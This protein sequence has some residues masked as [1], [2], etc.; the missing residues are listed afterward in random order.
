MVKLLHHIQ[1]QRIYKK[2]LTSWLQT[3]P[4]DV[5]V[6]L[7][8]KEIEWLGKTQLSCKKIAEL[9]FAIDY[10]DKWIQQT[11]HGLL[12]QTIGKFLTYSFIAQVKQMDELVVLTQADKEAWQQHNVTHVR[13]ILNPCSIMPN[14]RG[15]HDKKQ[16]LAVGRLE[17][18]KG[19]DWLIEAWGKTAGAYPEWTLKICGEGSQRTVLEKQIE[20]LGLTGRVEMNGVAEK[21]E[22]EY[23][24][25]RL[26]VLSSRYEGLP[27]A[28]M[29]AMSCGLCCIAMDCKQGP[30]ELIGNEER[31]RLVDLGDVEGLARAMAEEMAQEEQAKE[32]PNCVAK[33]V[34]EQGM[35]PEELKQLVP[36]LDK[37][38]GTLL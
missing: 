10:R 38:T 29:E 28:L 36:L 30:R 16:I 11:H 13:N 12:W 25:S 7:C 4:T 14:Q 18:Q 31:G 24:Q 1:K 37:L 22:E 5:C 21:L 9:H 23:M 34:V 2:H 35:S 26:F 3:H 27:L 6:S 17:P 8:G 32:I 19:F 15:S 33:A 20:E